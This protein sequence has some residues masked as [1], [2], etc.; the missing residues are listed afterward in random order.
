MIYCINNTVSISSD[1]LAPVDRAV[2]GVVEYDDMKA[3]IKS[4]CLRDMV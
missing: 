3:A 2:L 4:R 1:P